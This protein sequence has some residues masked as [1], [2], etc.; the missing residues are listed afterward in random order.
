M[1]LRRS[2]VVATGLLAGAIALAAAPPKALTAACCTFFLTDLVYFDTATNQGVPA[3]SMGMDDSTFDLMDGSSFTVTD[4]ASV[5]EAVTF[6]AGDFADISAATADEVAAAINAQLTI[7]EAFHEDGMLMIR[8]HVGGPAGTLELT[9]GNDSPLQMLGFAPGTMT[10]TEDIELRLATQLQDMDGG[11]TPGFPDHPYLVVMSATEGNVQVAGHTLPLAIDATTLLGLRATEL[12]LLP[13]FLADLDGEGG[14][15]TQYDTALL[16]KMFKS[17]TPDHL[18]FAFV[19]FK[20]DLSGVE[21]ISNRF[22][23]QVVD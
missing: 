19:V 22:S 8:G 13:G 12:G 1:K 3:Y 20:P 14:A 21:Y 4:G 17:G 11:V 2:S 23:V 5:T 16:P 18:Y 9:D 6:H 15:L 10:G 7:G